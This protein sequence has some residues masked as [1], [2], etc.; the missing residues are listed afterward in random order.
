MGLKSITYISNTLKKYS[1]LHIQSR[2]ESTE[3]VVYKMGVWISNT[4][5]LE[6]RSCEFE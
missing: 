4:P 6:I 3:L 2:V 1:C 5:Q